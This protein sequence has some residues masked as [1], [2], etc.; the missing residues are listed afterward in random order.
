MN[1][2][3]FAPLPRAVVKFASAF[4]LLSS[5]LLPPAAHAAFPDAHGVTLHFPIDF[6]IAFDDVVEYGA[7]IVIGLR[8]EIEGAPGQIAHRRQRLRVVL[9]H[10]EHRAA[11]A[12]NRCIARIRKG[13]VGCGR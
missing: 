3:D 9:A 4:I 7:Y 13:R 1:S 11:P 8:F 6:G 10:A 2:S 5:A 12:R